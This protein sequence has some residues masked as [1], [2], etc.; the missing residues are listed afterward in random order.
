MTDDVTVII[1]AAGKGARM[2]S[3][4]A[5]V[6]HHVGGRPMVVHVLSTVRE[7]NPSQLFLVIGKQNEILEQTLT[8]QGIEYV[9]QEHPL[10]TGHA[11]LQTE[12]KAT[13][14]TLLV[15][16]GDLPLLTSGALREF[17]SHHADSGADLSVLTMV[18]DK[19]GAYGR[20]VRNG[21]GNPMKIVEAQD[22]SE[23]EL[24]ICEV[25]TGIYCIRNDN[26]LWRTLAS[27]KTDNVQSEYY[28]TDLVAQYNKMGKRVMAFQVSDAK[29][30]MGVNSQ[31]ELAEADR[32][33]RR[34]KIEELMASGVTIIDPERT[35]ID[36]EV[37]VGADTTILPGTYLVGASRVG[38][39]GTIGPN[40][41]IDRSVIEA[42][43]R[44]WYAVIEESR[45]RE[46]TA[47]GP[48]AHLRPGADVGPDSRIGNF[49]EVKASRVKKGVKVGHLTYLGDAEVGED[50][51][52]GAGTITCN[53]DGEKKQRT[54]I[55][56][57]A[58][59]GSNVA[60]VAPIRIGDGAVIGAGST[61]TEDVPPGTLALGRTRQVIKTLKKKMKGE[62]DA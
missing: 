35:Y 52:I 3:A 21:E 6:L 9:I 25:N 50:T 2:K 11:V 16:P 54:T 62:E 48:Y 19:P 57:R 40:V 5:K 10:G 32:A 61:I 8:E 12:G 20:L 14:E 23:R 22:A 26:F 36:S 33:M 53:Y 28:L 15:I 41:W 47:V 43:C 37:V 45:V 42:G 55:G 27:L 30:V 1:L 39:G 59:I 44:I 58:F 17:L 56:A 51:N 29:V 31:R 46:N 4:R 34:R 7:L 49:V 18:M 24:E 38:G 60:L 13:E